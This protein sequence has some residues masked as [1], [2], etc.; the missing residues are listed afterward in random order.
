MAGVV[1]RVVDDVQF[2]RRKRSLKQGGRIR[3]AAVS[4]W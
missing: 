2:G 3:V 1:M 4:S